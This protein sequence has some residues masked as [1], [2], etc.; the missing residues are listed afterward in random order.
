LEIDTEILIG[1]YAF[2]SGATGG[3]GKA[4]SVALAEQG[5]NL[6]LTSSTDSG[7]QEVV[8]LCEKYNIEVEAHSGDLSQKDDIYKIIKHAKERFGKIDILIN[9]AGVFPNINLFEIDDELYSEVLNVNFR[10]AFLFIRE[11]SKDMVDQQWGRIV[12]IGSSSAYSGFGGTSMY[13]ASKH[14]LLGFSRAIHDEL[15]QYNVRSYYISPSS[16][17]SKMGLKTKGQDYTTFLEPTDIAKYVVFSISFDSNIMTEEI[18]LKRMVI[19]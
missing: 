18:F 11:F 1:K 16:T 13:C 12:N 4:I 14:A 15:K 8:E 2:I 17:Q 6:F 3:I 5:C 7:L 9:S 10:S 19:R